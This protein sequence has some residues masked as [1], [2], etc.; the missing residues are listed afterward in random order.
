M[1]ATNELGA[2]SDVA[3]DAVTILAQVGEKYLAKL[4]GFVYVSTILA[5]F[6]SCTLLYLRLW[7]AD[8][9]IIILFFSLI[10]FL[11]WRE[12]AMWTLRSEGYTPATYGA[13]FSA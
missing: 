11:K 6:N 5:T 4:S 13:Q 10:N 7:S 3:K 9:F 1:L 12:E 8:S 2:K